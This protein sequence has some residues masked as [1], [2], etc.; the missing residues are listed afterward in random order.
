MLEGGADLESVL[1]AEDQRMALAG[2]EMKGDAS[3]LGAMGMVS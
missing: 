2:L 1:V 3:A